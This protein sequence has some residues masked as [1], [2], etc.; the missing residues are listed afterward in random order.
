MLLSF[1][2]SKAGGDRKIVGVCTTNSSLTTYA[3]ESDDL[4]DVANKFQKMV[5]IGISLVTKYTKV[6]GKVPT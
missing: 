5:K 4:E 2:V 6:N 1:D 3:S